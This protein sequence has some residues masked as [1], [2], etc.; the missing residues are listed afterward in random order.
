[1]GLETHEH[2]E[3]VNV[4][5]QNVGHAAHQDAAVGERAEQSR[6]AWPPPAPPLQLSSFPAWGAEEQVGEGHLSPPT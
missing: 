4:T 2:M 5:Q 1:M 3:W 6:G